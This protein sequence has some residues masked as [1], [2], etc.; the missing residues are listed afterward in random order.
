MER[1]GRGLNPPSSFPSP[2]SDSHS[3]PSQVLIKQE[4][5]AP[6][7]MYTDNYV[8]THRRASPEWRPSCG[9]APAAHPARAPRGK[10]L[11]S[12]R[13]GREPGRGKPRSRA[14]NSLRAEAKAG[15]GEA[16]RDTH[17]PSGLRPRAP[18]GCSGARGA[19]SRAP[20]RSSAA[21]ASPA[22]SP[23]PPSPPLPGLASSD[24]ADF[25]WSR[26]RPGPPSAQPRNGSLSALCLSSSSTYQYHT[27]RTPTVIA[28]QANM[29]AAA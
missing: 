24:D 13:R 23:S 10:R 15:G 21:S 2:G 19:S 26:K 6:A 8:A 5:N 12:R 4:K 7:W 17:G 28:S 3:L 22:T 14:F 9:R 27:P 25:G 11:N 1:G 18:P 20:R 16:G 29:A